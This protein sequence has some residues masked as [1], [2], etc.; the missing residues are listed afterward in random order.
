MIGMFMC[1]EYGFDPLH[2]QSQ[3]AH[4]VF[5]LPAGDSGVD[6]YCF[7]FIADVVAVSVASGG[8]GGKV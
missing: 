2:G 3:P 8:E 5:R 1:D 4:P 7:V 6:Q